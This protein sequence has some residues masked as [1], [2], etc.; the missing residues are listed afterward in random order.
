MQPFLH[1]PMLRIEATH[2]VGCAALEGAVACRHASATANIFEIVFHGRGWHQRVF[3]QVLS[4][5][6]YALDI[7]VFFGNKASLWVHCHVEQIT[8]IAD[9]AEGVQIRI[10][11]FSEVTELLPRINDVCTVCHWSYL[12]ARAAARWLFAFKRAQGFAGCA[13]S[14]T[15]V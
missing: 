8:I 10:L 4:E 15:E 1:A 6:S 13:S 11:F 12:Y 5:V 3:S 14:M 2:R 7:L 9:V